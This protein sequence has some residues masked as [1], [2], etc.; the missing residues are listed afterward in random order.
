M[1]PG[2]GQI[3]QN[4]GHHGAIFFLSLEK[5]TIMAA[6][7]NF[8]DLTLG[9]S[10]NHIF[11]KLKLGLSYIQKQ[12][13]IQINTNLA[14]LYNPC[15]EVLQGWILSISGLYNMFKQVIFNIHLL[16]QRNLISFTFLT[17]RY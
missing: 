16:K 9:I 3:C 17:F 7:L 8:F 5:N 15:S 13:G 10:L 6:I 11:G 2:C 14:C 12:G 4:G 1:S